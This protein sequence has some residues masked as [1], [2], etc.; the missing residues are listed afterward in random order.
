VANR[1]SHL[2]LQ[3]LRNLLHRHSGGGVTDGQLLERFVKEREETAFEVLVWRH[4]PMV[5]ALGQRV[6]GNAHDAEDV[7]QATFLTLVRKAGSIGKS[8]SL[9]SWLYKVAYR[10]ALR[11]RTR[12]AKTLADGRLVEDVPVPSQTE[13]ADWSELRPLLDAA[14]ERL[15]EKY[16]AAIVLCDLQGKSHREAAEQLGCAV[17]TVSTRLSRA[18]Q[19]LRKRLA[20]HGLSVSV[21]ALGAVL[22]QQT[23]AAMSAPPHRSCARGTRPH[24]SRRASPN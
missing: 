7:L 4:G 19:L 22:A 18:R 13:E 23:A 1:Q 15:P 6:L 3:Y 2:I 20:H 12:T 10:I 24:L 11:S 17:G 9:S 14:I 16:R 21:A 8:E 5:L